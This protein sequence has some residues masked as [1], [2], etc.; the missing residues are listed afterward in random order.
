MTTP[1]NRSSINSSNLA[2]LNTSSGKEL[3]KTETEH[4]T[5]TRGTMRYIEYA[6]KRGFLSAQVS[7]IEKS[8]QAMHKVISS[9]DLFF[10]IASFLAPL[11]SRPNE[12]PSQ[13]H[14][15][16]RRLV[17]YTVT[18]TKE[19][20]SA[21]RT[22]TPGPSS[23]D[24]MALAVSSFREL[25]TQTNG[26]LRITP[27][28]NCEY[29]K[30]TKEQLTDLS[31]FFVAF[32]PTEKKEET[33]QKAISCAAQFLL[34]Q[35]N[36]KKSVLHS[37]LTDKPDNL[38]PFWQSALQEAGRRV[39]TFKIPESLRPETLFFLLGCF[40]N[41]KAIDLSA[42]KPSGLIFVEETIE[43]FLKLLSAQKKL[44]SLTITHYDLSDKALKALRPLRNLKRLHVDGNWLTNE[45]IATLSSMKHPLHHLSL[46]DCFKL[47][48]EPFFAY[49]S[50]LNA[51]RSLTVDERLLAKNN[52]SRL[53]ERFGEQLETLEITYGCDEGEDLSQKE[54]QA[55]GKFT[56]LT[57]LSLTTRS[58]ASFETLRAI[59]QSGRYLQDLTI[60]SYLD[61]RAASLYPSTREICEA[62]LA[63]LQN[64]E[65]LKIGI[66]DLPDAL[67]ETLASLPKLKTVQLY[68]KADPVWDAVENEDG[69][70]IP[71]NERDCIDMSQPAY[72]E[73]FI[74]KTSKNG[75]KSFSIKLEDS[76]DENN[77][78]NYILTLTKKSS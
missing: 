39:T 44:E 37:V 1:S 9:E 45:S 6:K 33:L 26:R 12:Y 27:N 53:A 16:E 3:E 56:A 71:E 46:Q 66:S 61:F 78:L 11:E 62:G 18:T 43:A 28:S 5:T 35:Q 57:K 38:S 73:E 65:F 72:L 68:L 77:D 67:F 74:K 40:P 19:D 58:P 34:S 36:E 2:H 8:K 70:P 31:S 13:K 24:S 51:L 23:A 55:I 59:I 76:P 52:L 69:T 21:R 42:W 20:L 54:M 48:Q 10:Q 15:S 14:P 29:H 7:T 32:T 75:W 47:G 30:S 50:Q 25:T 22:H 4:T 64:L 63:T 41:L 49:V 60:F 17:A